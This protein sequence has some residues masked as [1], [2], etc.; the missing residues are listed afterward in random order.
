MTVV[1]RRRF[2]SDRPPDRVLFS[3]LGDNPH[4]QA[5][6]TGPGCDR[7]RDRAAWPACAADLHGLRSVAAL[8]C[9]PQNRE[10]LQTA[11]GKRLPEASAGTDSRIDELR[12]GLPEPV[13]RK[14][15]GRRPLS[16]FSS[17]RSETSRPGRDPPQGNDR[18]RSP[19]RRSVDHYSEVHAMGS[20]RLLFTVRD[21]FSCW[22]DCGGPR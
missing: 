6:Q 2:G 14:P 4:A 12:M 8:A 22:A 9:A 20:S 15:T 3:D 16:P 10:E 19:R 5:Q 21:V 13:E 1:S 11:P 17:S 7:A 18:V